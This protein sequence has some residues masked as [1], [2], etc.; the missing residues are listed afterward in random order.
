MKYTI[1][2]NEEKKVLKSENY[3]YV[4]N[5]ANGNFYRWG[6]TFND[7]PQVGLP[8]IADIEITTKCSG[9]AGKLCKFCYKANTPNGDNMSL[10]TFKI[11][12]EKLPKSITQIAFGADANCTSNP[13]I[14]KI[15]EATRDAG[16]I[17][18]ITVADIDDRVAKR[19]ADLT[20]ACAVSR[21]ENKD[22]CYNSIKKLSD[23]VLKQKILVK[24]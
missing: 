18:N 3:N 23:S 6:K 22:L 5:K 10:E 9:P 16:I 4:F 17:P 1:I 11:I 15:M 19:L 8:E 20:G 7:D 21:Y 2:D 24:K 12:L 14:F 13:D